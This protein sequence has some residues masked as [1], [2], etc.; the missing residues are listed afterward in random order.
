MGEWLAEEKDA[1]LSV[2]GEIRDAM[3]RQ[4]DVMESDVNIDEDE[5]IKPEIE[6]AEERVAQAYIDVVQQFAVELDK[7]I[8]ATYL[9]DM[10]RVQAI[11]SFQKKLQNFE[12]ISLEG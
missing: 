10:A 8:T 11:R 6:Q 5:L 7:L 4:A 9:H 3:C 12:G 2:L 1:L